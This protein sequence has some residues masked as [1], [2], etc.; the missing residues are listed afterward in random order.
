[1]LF[2]LDNYKRNQL[3]YYFNQLNENS[4]VF[5]SILKINN[6]ELITWKQAEDK[7]SLLEIIC[8]LCD[9]EVADFR[10]RVLNILSNPAEPFKTID[11]GGWVKQRNY[12]K[13]NYEMKM[14]QFLN[15][16]N[17]SIEFLKTQEK[18]NWDN[19][20]QHPTLGAMSAKFMLTNWI[21]HDY[22]HIRQI[23]K[24]KYEYLASISNEKQSYAGIW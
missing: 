24:L 8:H 12:N 13:Q 22:L 20:H 14:Q 19:V 9:E 7:W 3:L 18:A 16:R 2:H 5:E 1:M 6:N 11:P 15:E 23:V 17:I 4:K 10:A 21:S